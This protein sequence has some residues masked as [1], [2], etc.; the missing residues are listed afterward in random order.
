MNKY[1]FY[2]RVKMKEKR[3][4]NDM[5]LCVINN[6][7]CPDVLEK[8]TKGIMFWHYSYYYFFMILIIFIKI[9]I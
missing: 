6:E 2:F 3:D 4:T 8:E 5:E 7:T 1:N 9:N